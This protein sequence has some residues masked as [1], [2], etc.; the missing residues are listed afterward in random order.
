MNWRRIVITIAQIAAV[1]VISLLFSK[2]TIYELTSI[3]AMNSSMSGMDFKMSDVYNSVVNQT[4]ETLR[5]KNVAIVNIDDC[6]REEVAEVIRLLD[7][8]SPAAVGLDEIY[9]KEKKHDAELISALRS[10]R[11]LV[12]PQRILGYKNRPDYVHEDKSYFYDDSFAHYGV[13]NLETAD[14]DCP[15]RRFRPVYTLQD[16]TEVYGMATE[17]VRIASPEAFDNLM[18]KVRSGDDTL[19]VSYPNVYFE[20]V[21]GEELLHKRDSVE[22]NFRG[23][24]LAAARDSLAA[25]FA[26]KIVLVGELNDGHDFHLTPIDITMPGV[27]IQAYT[28]ETILSEKFLRE[29][30]EEQ[31]WKIAIVICIIFLTLNFISV[32]HFPNVGKVLLRLLQIGCLFQCYIIGSIIYYYN[33]L[34]VDF[35]PTFTMIA[36]GFFSY[37]IWVGAVG[38]V[39]GIIRW[40]RGRKARR[41]KRRAKFLSRQRRLKEKWEA[42]ERKRR[43][44]EAD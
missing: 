3:P 32:N 38:I 39:Q 8:F 12:L 30:T 2:T 27:K 40:F 22:K 7:S 15:V 43:E 42:Q 37:D 16:S 14:L 23:A 33:G 20:T 36:L 34:Y 29:A 4:S 44:Q 6:S 1:T 24:E 25:P 31:N 9:P 21:T 35:M 17:L 26:G 5:S 13:L 41:E 28:V 19:L 18:K 10:C 11:N